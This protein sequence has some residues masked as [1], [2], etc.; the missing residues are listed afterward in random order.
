[1]NTAKKL[2]ERAG[3]VKKNVYRKHYKH[4]CAQEPVLKNVAL[5]QATQFL[6]K[7]KNQSLFGKGF[8]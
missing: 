5:A 6:P 3:T 7:A 8:M 4:A 1:M 2:S